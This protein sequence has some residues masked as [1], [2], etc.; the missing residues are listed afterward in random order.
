MKDITDRTPIPN[1]YRCRSI[2]IT[3]A[4]GFMGKI[5]IEKLVRSCPEIG[6]VYLLIRP[7][8]TK[9]VPSR[10]R[11]LTNCQVFDWLRQHR[12]DALEKLIPVS[13]DVSLPNLGIEASILQELEENVSVVFN[14]AA[15]VKFDD[16]LRSAIDANVKGPKRVAIFCR[17]L[18]NLKTFIHVS[19]AFNNLDKDE[20]SEE[21]FPTSL[22]PE[23]LMNFVDSIDDQML[24]SITKQLV[25]KCPNVYAYSKA[26]GEQLLRNLCE[27]DEQRLPLVIVRPSIVTAAL[28][29]PLPGW[30][31]NLNGPSGMIVGIAK[32]LVRTVRVD[33]RLVADL[34]PVDIAINLMIA[35]AWDRASSYTLAQMIP[36][37]H[38]S[39]GSLNPIRWEDFSR[40]GTRAGEKFPMKTEI[41][42]YPSASLRTN[43]FAFKFEVALYH[44]LP[45]FVVDTVA[46]LCWKKPFLTRLYKKVHK[47]MSCL[48]FYTMR[49]WHFVS[50][51]PDLLLEKM[52]AE[53]RN[54][55]NFDVRK[56]NW[57]SYMES[58]VL[59]VR[60]YLL[61]E[62][63][64]TLDLRRSNLK[65]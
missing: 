42:W 37:Y 25:G 14:S 3:G 15:R 4:T 6:S 65:M 57:E 44:Y 33:S 52:S 35:A 28:S 34:I 43:G 64:S 38:C 1:F 62:D 59:G 30:I 51:N 21:I 32:G 55:Y 36:V 40:Y 19:T 24:A 23:I 22:D 50:R 61:K 29:E 18:K 16:N 60:K 49:Q 7:T 11:E 9:D 12:P 45:A 26:L 58:Y 20:L 13:G 2:F 63:S 47:A 31:D 5:L 27:C 54:T 56:I 53:D 8:P 48:E 10:L 41:I 17:K 46:V 39:S